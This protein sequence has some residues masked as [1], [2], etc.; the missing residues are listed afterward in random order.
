MIFRLSSAQI[1]LPQKDGVLTTLFV[2]N[3]IGTAGDVH[4]YIAIGSE[5]VRRQK[6]V[7][8]LT[9][10]NYRDL[11]E[12][13]RIPFF[14]VGEELVIAKAADD[15][16]LQK[17]YSAWKAAMQW[18]ATGMM[19]DVYAKIQSV[20]QPNHTV[21][22]SPVWSLGARLARETLPILHV[23][24]LLNPCLLR[25]Y[26][27]PPVLPLMPNASWFPPWFR[28][29]QYWI[30]DR[31]VLDP[32]ISKELNRF[33]SELHLSPVSRVMNRWWFSP[34]LVLGLFSERLVPRSLD[35]PVYVELVGH[36]LWDP[37]TSQA[38]SDKVQAFL[39]EHPEPIA[40]VPGSIGLGGGSLLGN[41][42]EACCRLEKPVLVLTSKRDHLPS[43][44][45]VNV[46]YCPYVPLSEVFGHC[47]MV[48][49]SGCI[50]TSCQVLAAGIPQMVFPQ[51]NDQFDNAARLSRLGV[52]ETV[53]DKG[54][55]ASESA[56]IIR[57]LLMDKGASKN[58]IQLKS[59][60]QKSSV[61]RIVERLIQVV[62][63]S[64]SLSVRNLSDAVSQ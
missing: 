57:R 54:I 44:L 55:S 48:V 30:A 43:K 46:H 58:S 47:A 62:P 17:P 14:P 27:N 19:R 25:S 11:A 49:H 8:L 16:R 52:S 23:N 61:D 59:E 38:N 5:L 63:E 39:K 13:Y 20:H 36:T 15:Q 32:L 24:A 40:I 64:R 6:Q 2:L 18:A 56:E 1:I 51:V 21:V 28:R 26:C 35:W 12:S 3:P 7:L 37:S 42:I 22:V 33:R 50:G 31:F 53:F 9:T 29:L 41:L 10:P 60:F 4:P 45:P 34:D